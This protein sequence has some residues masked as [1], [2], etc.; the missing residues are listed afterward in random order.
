VWNLLNL[1]A[2]TLGVAYLDDSSV[3]EQMV[4]FATGQFR[5]G[6]LPLDSWFP[7]LGLGSPQFLHYQSLPAMLTG[8]AGLLVGPDAAFRWTLYLLLSVWPVAVYLSARLLGAGRPAAATAAAMSPFLV[9]TTGIGYEQ[10]AYVWVGYGVWTQLWASL[11]L[12]LSWGF[13]WRAIRD[14]R[15]RF[16]AVALVSLTI[17]L[18]FETGYLALL[19]LLLWPFVSGRSIVTGVKRAATVAGGALLAAAWV[20][21][22]LIDQR[23]WAATNEALHGTALSG[24]YGAAR[25]LGWLGS[26]QLLDHGRIPVVTGFAVIGLV[27]ALA[28]WRADAGSRALVMAL[29]GC[30]LLSF[31]RTTFGSLVAVI[32]GN[33]DIFF[34]RFMMGV[35]LAALLLAG[36]GAAWCAGWAWNALER[37]ALRPRLP[38]HEALRRRLAWRWANPRM[39]RVRTAVA[40]G[41]MIVVLAPA[42]LEQRSFDH[43]N[44]DH[45]AAQRRADAAQ[46]AELDQLIALI[47]ENGGGRVYAGMPSNWGADFTVGAVPV[48]K[49]LES[50]DVDEV[51]YTLRTA[52]LMTGPENH[53]DELDPSDYELFGIRY[54]IL[55]STSA[56]PVSADE[57]AV[58][59]PYAL[60][61]T[62]TTGYVHVGTNGGTITADRTDLGAR[63]IPLLR[64]GLAQSGDYLRVHFGGRQAT[65][66]PLPR[67]STQPAAGEVTAESDDLEH[68]AVSTTVTMRRPGVVVL[69]ASFDDGW[70]ATIDGRRQPTAMAGPALVAT[71]V[72]AGTHVITFRYHGYSGYPELFVLCALT[73]AAFAGADAMR[74]RRTRSPV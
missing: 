47:Q 8:V 30:L 33:G 62:P 58:A 61:T 52:S 15:H 10:N 68:G 57:V 16:A 50:A 41:A 71:N 29:A 32:P 22:P 11:T 60:W 46:G 9:S 37:L 69:S 26:G 18:H 23:P 13:T 59:G 43:R 20:I 67:S 19:P 6:H 34:R 44:A 40:L 7:F 2:E 53:F 55:P 25:V 14:G 45:I 38:P 64:S 63:S 48:F 36:R 35:Q 73:L 21:V 51:G 74:R 39:G 42:W 17:A 3:Q 31:G 70:S 27:V 66:P 54:L 56:P 49:Y 28:R 5:S 1:R 4:R 24:G 12:P 72:P 65:L